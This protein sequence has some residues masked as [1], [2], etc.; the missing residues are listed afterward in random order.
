[1]LKIRVQNFLD[2]LGLPKSRLSAKVGISAKALSRWLDGDLN[3]SQATQKRIDDFLKKFNSQEMN[4][5]DALK[6]KL[7]EYLTVQKLT[8]MKFAMAAQINPISIYAW[9]NND[10]YQLDNV[11]RARIISFINK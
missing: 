8:P 7:E 1:M 5:I 4:T 6:K 9:L 2:A 10:G 3:L 11:T